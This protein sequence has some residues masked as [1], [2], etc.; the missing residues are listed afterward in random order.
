MSDDSSQDDSQKTEDPTPKR[1]KEMR[2]KGQVVMSRE[3]NSWVMLFTG[4]LI[5]LAIGPWMFEGLAV[6]MRSFIERPHSLSV[7]GVGLMHL[8]VDTFKEIA[9]YMALPILLLLIASIGAPFAQIG[10]LFSAEPLKPKL[11]KISPIAGFKRLFGMRALFEFFKGLVKILIVGIVIAL[12][13]WPFMGTLTAHVG[14]SMPYMMHYISDLLAKVLIGVLAVLFVLAVL[15]YLYQRHEFMEKAKMS[16]K[17]IKDEYKQTEGDPHVKAKLRSLRQE[18]A[19]TRMMDAVPKADVII[20]NP[21]HFAVA[22]QYE[23]DEMNAPRLIAK[24]QD[25]LALKIREMA[26]ELDIEIMEN[27]PL[28]RALYAAMDID[29]EIPPEHYK[30]VAGVIKYVFAKKGKK[31]G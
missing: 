26:K 23:P 2:D 20:T 31:L 11:D 5:L 30:A 27:P 3:V 13:V 29:D 24:G 8:M 12:I 22:L 4:A 1:L 28:A 7:D 15:D 19:R 9:L 18:R 6:M 14:Q 17:D 16:L 25:F 10:A 21:T